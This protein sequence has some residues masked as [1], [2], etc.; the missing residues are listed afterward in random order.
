MANVNTII[1]YNN[2]TKRGQ[3]APSTLAVGTETAVVVNT[4]TGTTALFLQVP[5]QTAILGSSSG[6]GPNGN[7]AILVPPFGTGNN[8]PDGVNAPYFNSSSFDLGRPFTIKM[9]GTAL[10]VAGTG[11]SLAIKLYQGTTTA[12]IGGTSFVAPTAIVG[13]TAVNLRFYISVTCYWDSVSQ[14]LTGTLSGQT[15]TNGTATAISPVAATSITGI[16]S[17]AGLSFL[18]TVTWGNAVGGLVTF[19]EISLEAL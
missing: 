2:G 5:L 18:P 14:V 13:A 19:S 3:I 6:I 10:P 9:I 7:A 12:V 11:N 17:P 16:T 4:D 8:I 15:V 1:C